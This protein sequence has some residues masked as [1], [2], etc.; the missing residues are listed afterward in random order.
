MLRVVAALLLLSVP[1][2]A[3]DVTSTADSGAGTLREGVTTALGLGGANTLAW[4]VGGTLS[5]LTDLPGIGANT[6]IDF[7]G[8]GAPVTIAS[9]PGN[10]PLAGAVTF[11]VGAQAATVSAS[12]TG[13]GSLIKTGAGLLDLTASNSYSGGTTITA[14][15]LRI[16]NVSGLGSGAL[17]FNGGTLQLNVTSGTL[18]AGV[19]LNA[20]GTIDTMGNTGIISSAVGGAG[21]LTLSSS[22]TLVLQAANTFTGGI[23]ATAANGFITVSQD[24]SLGA[25][26]GGVTLS[27]GGALRWAAQFDSARAIT[28]GAG[29]GILDTSGF[30]PR[31]SGLISGAGA[32]TKNGTGVLTLT[33]TN[34]YTGGTTINAGTVVVGATDALGPSGAL[35]VNNGAILDLGAFT[36]NVTSFAG[37]DTLK[38]ALQAGGARLIATG[39][40]NLTNTTLSVSLPAQLAQPAA[41]YTFT[42][43]SGGS[44]TGLPAVSGPAAISFTPSITGGGTIL[45]LTP[46]FVPFASIAAT[47]NQAAIGRTLETFRAAPGTGDMAAVLGELY[48]L[49]AHDVQGALDQIG[50]G[51]LGAMSGVGMAQ[52]SVQ[53]AAVSRRMASLADGS[54]GSEFANYSVTGR[55]SIPGTLLAEAPGDAPDPREER[56]DARSPWGLF[57]AAV[58]TSGRLNEANG[59]SGT[60]PG[61]SFNTGGLTAGFDYRFDNGWAAG[62]AAGYLHGHASLNIPGGGTVDDSSARYGVYVTRADESLHADLYVGGASDWFKTKRGIAFGGLTRTASASPKGTEFNVHPALAYDVRVLRRSTLSPFASLNYNRLDVGSFSETGADSLN[63]SVARQTS[64]SVESTLGLRFSQR[65]EGEKWVFTPYGS[66]GWRHEY[67]PQ[68]RPI[69]AQLAAGGGTFT[70]ASGNI[71]R[72]GTL[73]GAGLAIDV[74]RGLTLKLDYAGDFRSHYR[75]SMVNLSARL[76][77]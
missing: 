30:N 39:N 43:V 15:T 31:L 59:L 12:I 76:R 16:W 58:F 25:A 71:A 32:L 70:V 22:G 48:S 17:T 23:S 69:D 3:I 67:T 73:I 46:T 34:T 2:R 40:V 27:G 19:T 75:D 8:S 29:G 63:L 66:L 62:F 50:P 37:N 35:V 45:T 41:N 18:A 54:A 47:G 72:D 56:G 33:N 26:A 9:L 38:M 4:T 7:S 68:S 21:S 36:Q 5:L 53:S 74:S 20:G 64:E 13:A 52:A 77:F 6:T 60:Q 44:F 28:L 57:T 51:A 65:V 61:Y 10:V 24:A 14:G 11:Q 55:S 49:G 42:P 1:A